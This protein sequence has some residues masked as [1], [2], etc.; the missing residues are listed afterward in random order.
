VAEGRGDYSRALDLHREALAISEE[1]GERREQSYQLLGMGK[2]YFG[3]GELDDAED[4]LRRSRE[5]GMPETGYL[6]AMALGFVLQRR[7]SD[8]VA[9]VFAD[10]IQR[11][12][13]RLSRSAQLF[14]AHY[15][16]ATALVATAALMPGWGDESARAALLAPAFDA[17]DQAVAICPG[18][19]IVSATVRDLECLAEGGIVGLEPAKARLQAL[20]P[21]TRIE[22]VT[23]AMVANE[24]ST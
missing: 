14:G 15:T 13:E 18:A 3:L 16:R 10:T 6:A 12:D 24:G 5:L 17:W 9:A 11:C 7:G 23:P 1:L 21:E 20:L 4:N 22:P 8:D 19:G 2:A